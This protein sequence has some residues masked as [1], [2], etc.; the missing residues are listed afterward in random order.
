MEKGSQVISI[1]VPVYNVGNTIEQCISSVLKQTHENFELIIVDDGSSDDSLEKC[2]KLEEQDARIRVH[3]KSNSG[4]SN[5]RNVGINHATGDWICF[6]DADD[7][8]DSDYLEKMYAETKQKSKICDVVLAGVRIINNGQ[9]FE[10]KYSRRI[11]KGEESHELMQGLFDNRKLP[12][13]DTQTAGCV[14]GVLYSKELIQ[15]I[16]FHEN[17]SIREDAFF[18]YDALSKAKTVVVS[19]YVGYNYKID[20][21]STMAKFKREYNVEIYK[22]LNVCHESILREGF[23]LNVYYVAVLYA[24]MMWLKIFLLHKDS[25]MKKEEVNELLTAS[26]KN[27]IWHGAFKNVEIST[28]PVHYVVLRFCFLNHLKCGIKMLY[29]LSRLRNKT[30]K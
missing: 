19:D 10:K 17:I 2:K 24:Y 5:T 12:Y 14:W 22:Y 13:I 4:V 20:D 18:V 27:E 21:T 29:K 25:N 30:G 9:E 15:N 23:S 3:H 6:V 11:F 16:R 7:Y 26:F 28:L 1:I 8:I